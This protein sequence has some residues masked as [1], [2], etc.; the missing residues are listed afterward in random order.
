MVMILIN[1]SIHIGIVILHRQNVS[2][3][4]TLQNLDDDG[5]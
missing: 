5:L 2:I 3:E 1:R 4:L